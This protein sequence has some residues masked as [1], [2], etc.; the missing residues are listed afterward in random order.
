M[1]RANALEALGFGLIGAAGAY[2]HG[3]EWLGFA[4]CGILGLALL[5]ADE[6]RRARRRKVRR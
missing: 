1:G 3:R 5:T 6:V 2:V 4:A